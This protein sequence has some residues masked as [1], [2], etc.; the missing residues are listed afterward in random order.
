MGAQGQ[1]GHGTAQLQ[2]PVLQDELIEIR[3][4]DAQPLDQK[5]LLF[6][7]HP[8]AVVG[9]LQHVVEADHHQ[10]HHRDQRRHQRAGR[11]VHQPTQGHGRFS[12]ASTSAAT[13]P[14]NSFV[15]S[16]SAMMR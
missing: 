6:L 1:F 2:R 3:L 15:Q 12:A 9:P 13:R 4:F 16:G 10:R 11:Q 7:F 5:L 14:S 8:Q